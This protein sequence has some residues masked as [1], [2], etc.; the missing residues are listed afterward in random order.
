MKK[1]MINASKM[2]HIEMQN[3]KDMMEMNNLFQKVGKGKRKYNIKLSYSARALLDKT[4]TE[5]RKAI[6]YEGS[7]PR[8]FDE[9]VSYISI[10]TKSKEGFSLTFDEINFLKKMINLTIR[11][12]ENMK[13]PWY[14]VLTRLFASLASIQYKEILANLKV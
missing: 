10:S 5:M 3:M 9:F 13:L 8:N 12:Q 2:N 14:K 1:Q 6:S 7:V 11:Q 4:L